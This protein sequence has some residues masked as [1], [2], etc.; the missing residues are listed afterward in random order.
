MR[1][2]RWPFHDLGPNLGE[3]LL[4]MARII[5]DHIDATAASAQRAAR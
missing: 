5:R 1:M 3:E 2:V 4:L